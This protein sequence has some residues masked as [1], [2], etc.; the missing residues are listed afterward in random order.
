MHCQLI[1]KGCVDLLV[2]YST[3]AH[4]KYMQA[5]QTHFLRHTRTTQIHARSS[6]AAICTQPETGALDPSGGSSGIRMVR[7]TGNIR[8]ISPNQLHLMRFS[9][10]PAGSTSDKDANRLS[11]I[12]MQ[13]LISSMTQRSDC[14]R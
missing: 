10:E 5:R 14:R 11:N 8:L 4:I 7:A 1:A 9:T 3:F 13:V 12:F 2:T 6:S